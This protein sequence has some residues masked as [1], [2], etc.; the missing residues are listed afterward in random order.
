MIVNG[1]KIATRLKE[2]IISLSSSGLPK[3]LAIFYVGENPVID[4]YVNLKKK[5]GQDVGIR[6]EVF[7]FPENIAE[8][9]LLRAIVSETEKFDGAIVQLPLP[10]AIDKTRILN[11]VN[12]DK[13]VDMLS[14]ES[15]E[16]FVKW[17]T[18]RLPPVVQAISE[19]VKEY[20]IDFSGKSIL[21]IGMGALVGKPVVLWLQ[22]EGFEPIVADKDTADLTSLTQ[23]A[24]VIISGAGVPWIVRPEMVQ[25]G[26]I[27]IDAGASTASGELRGDIDPACDAK[28]KI[29]S[30]VPGGLG[31][32][33]VTALFKNLFL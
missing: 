20:A 28:A 17:R 18:M 4:S 25:E 13:D 30:T 29:F 21:V 14:S 8:D 10:V 7:R 9:Q 32:I 31:P 1:K 27:L 22:R 12:S 5:F 16:R 6:V 23:A 24:D 11:A 26:V 3:S 19:V 33:T 15:V 2:E